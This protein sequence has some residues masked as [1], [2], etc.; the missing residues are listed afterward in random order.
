LD[1][2]GLLFQW[3]NPRNDLRTDGFERFDGKY[4]VGGLRDD[5]VNIKIRKHVQPPPGW[6]DLRLCWIKYFSRGN[7]AGAVDLRQHFLLVLL[8]QTAANGNTGWGSVLDQLNS[9]NCTLGVLGITSTDLQDIPYRELNLIGKGAWLPS[10]GLDGGRIPEAVSLFLRDSKT[11]AREKEAILPLRDGN[12]ALVAQARG[13]VMLRPYNAQSPIPAAGDPSQFIR[14]MSIFGLYKAYEQAMQQATL[15]VASALN[16]KGENRQN[17]Q[18]GLMDLQEALAEFDA[19][20]YF[21]SPVDPTRHE[22]TKCANFFATYSTACSQ[23]A[24]LS[25]QIERLG[26]LSRS[27]LRAREE[28]A[29]KQR[30]RRIQR[31]MAMIAVIALLFT[32]GQLLSQP[33]DQFWEVLLQWL[34]LIGLGG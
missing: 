8:G 30:D 20:Y 31:N 1:F 26:T 21:K 3:V 2:A 28:K 11:L 22:L 7:A 17:A 19:R 12:A 10:V 24:D 15:A 25:G 16:K 13:F 23:H 27:E 32:A 4:L 9:G 5:G 29:D 34:R 18:Q 33:P 14:Q 6:E